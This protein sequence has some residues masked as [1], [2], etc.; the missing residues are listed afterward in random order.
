MK[1]YKTNKIVLRVKNNAS[2]FLNGLTANSLDKSNNAF[3]DIHGK[4]IA[5][6][7]QVKTGE[8]EFWLLIERP[9]VEDVLQHLDRYT[10]LSK[11]VLEKKEQ[12][13]VF[14]DLEGSYRAG[15]GEIFIP[16]K[17]GQLIITTKELDTNV[18]N[19]E[20]TLFRIKNNI[21]IHGIDYKDEFLLNVSE[22]DFV[23]F[24]KGCFLG[25]EPVS[26]VHSRS[27]PSWKL[28]VKYEDECSEEEKAKMTSKVME[29]RKKRY[30][31]FIFVSNR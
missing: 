27:K 22:V 5:T 13:H 8:D 16:Q 17:K 14:F 26:K 24:T 19:E 21:P 6:F 1:L 29:P 2:Q 3:L 31:G 18:S 9:F 25:Q 4:I 23:S 15:S 12:Y 20:F 7:D 30:L 11:T 28:M 10:R